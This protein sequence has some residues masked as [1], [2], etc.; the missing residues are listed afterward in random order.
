M[1]KGVL[2][3]CSSDAHYRTDIGIFTEALAVFKEV[4]AGP[5]HVINSSVEQFEAFITKRKTLRKE[6]L[7]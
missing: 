1:E 3:C 5:E 2:M 7:K 4:H 6:A